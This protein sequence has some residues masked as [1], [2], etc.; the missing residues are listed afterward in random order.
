MPSP[1]CLRCTHV[2]QLWSTP[3]NTPPLLAALFLVAILSP[4]RTLFGVLGAIQDVSIGFSLA[5]L[6][7]KTLV[8]LALHGLT[9]TA[10]SER[11][12][13]WVINTYLSK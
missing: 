2:R 9:D 7:S 13:G 1:P 6:D 12:R 3:S 8:L 5:L 11:H 10:V 4:D